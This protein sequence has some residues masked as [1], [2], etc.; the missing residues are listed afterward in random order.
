[1]DWPSAEFARFLETLPDAALVADRGGRLVLAN[2]RAHAVLGHRTGTLPG[3]ALGS[4][5]V[6]SNRDSIPEL[7]RQLAATEGAAGEL[8]L[9][10]AGGH[11][12]TVQIR[13]APVALAGSEDGHV[14]ILL[15]DITEEK[16]GR[17]LLQLSADRLTQALRV[18]RMGIFDHD[19]VRDT[20]YWS[21]EQRANYGWGPDETVTLSKFLE[22]VYPADRERIGDAVR[23]AHNPSG[24]GLF[25]VEHRIIRRDGEIRWLVTRSQ[26]LFDGAEAERRPVRTV[27]AVLD[28]TEQRRAEEELRLFRQ[29]TD[30]A[31]ESIFWLNRDGKLLYVNESAC[32]SLG[33]T[34]EEL[35]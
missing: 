27:G 11:R 17:D 1:M 22:Q 4:L 6:P 28:V 5:L 10:P 7:I 12:S 21:P 24:D 8:A 18:S 3:Q 32:Q 30:L 34:R 23:L 35:L 25:D 26:T 15:R 9:H 16:K 19:H 2:T 14:V 20:V 33:Y 31:T 13:V 29:A